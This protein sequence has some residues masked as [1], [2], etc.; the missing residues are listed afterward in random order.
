MADIVCRLCGEPW[1][2]Y[3]AK[4][5]S[6]MT[7]EEY[8]M[9]RRGLGCPSCDFGAAAEPATRDDQAFLESLAEASDD[10]DE[11]NEAIAVVE[12]ADDEETE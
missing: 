11:V 12:R 5:G 4:T 2:A 10:A 1:D 8:E 9:F 7:E 3:G 6:D